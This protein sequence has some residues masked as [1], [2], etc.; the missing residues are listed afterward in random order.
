M[1]AKCWAFIGGLSTMSVSECVCVCG[2]WLVLRHIFFRFAVPRIPFQSRKHSI[3]LQLK[4]NGPLNGL[5]IFTRA[6]ICLNFFVLHS[7]WWWWQ[8]AEYVCISFNQ[9]RSM[10]GT[11]WIW[12]HGLMAEC[13]FK[14]IRDGGYGGTSKKEIYKV[15]TLSQ[16][17]WLGNAIDSSSRSKFY[18]LHLLNLRP[19]SIVFIRF[20]YYRSTLSSF[21]V[22]SIFPIFISFVPTLPTTQNWKRWKRKRKTQQPLLRIKIKRTSATNRI[23]LSLTGTRRC[24]PPCFGWNWRLCVCVW[25]WKWS[26]VA[27]VYVIEAISK[28]DENK[29]RISII[30]FCEAFTN[31]IDV[32]VA[33]RDD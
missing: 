12:S 19:R 25:V 9:H 6:H 10:P 26:T 7:S 14:P 11:R 30:T 31:N 17:I 3:E 27:C 5:S 22:I 28:E 24:C 33:Q 20:H 8:D 21:S 32:R 16:S 4:W 2:V 29:L 1:I 13:Q 18:C 15:K 23:C